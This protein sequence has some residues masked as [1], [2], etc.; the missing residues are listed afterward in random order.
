MLIL[1]TPMGTIRVTP[2]PT[3]PTGWIIE[4]TGDEIC[5]FSSDFPHVEGGRNPLRRFDNEVEALSVETKDKFFRLNFENL[6]GSAMSDLPTN[7]G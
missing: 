6:M 2:F 5:M 7:S 3:E 4:N 1:G